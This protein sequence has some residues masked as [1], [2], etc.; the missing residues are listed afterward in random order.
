MLII[1]IAFAFLIGGFSPAWSGEKDMALDFQG[2]TFSAFLQAA[3]LRFILEK[4]EKEKGI[5]FKG[6]SSLLGE[7]IT[8]QFTSLSL[9]DGMKRI[10]SSMNYSLVFGRN[11]ELHGVVIIGRGMSKRAKGQNR[12]VGAVRSTSSTIR[13]DD[14][15]AIGA[16]EI[17]RDSQPLGAHVVMTERDLERF[18]VIKNVSPPGGSLEVKAKDFT[19]FTVVRDCP[20]PGGPIEVSEEQL[21]KF[22]IVENCPPPGS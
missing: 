17:V 3:P 5:W 20:P 1:F 14:G 13:K 19:D 6:A 11:G 7:E 16:F 8:V 9:E 12:T 10:L 22:K 21:E 4:L 18:K 2:Q 15:S